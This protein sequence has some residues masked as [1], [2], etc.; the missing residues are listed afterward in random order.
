MLLRLTDHLGE[1][2]VAELYLA[3]V[4]QYHGQHTPDYYDNS[5]FCGDSSHLEEGWVVLVAPPG[6]GPS[7]SNM[8]FFGKNEKGTNLVLSIALCY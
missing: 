4:S 5:D 7:S 2:F 1:D 3:L 8:T 6:A